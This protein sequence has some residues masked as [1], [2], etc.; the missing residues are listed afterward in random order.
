MQTPGDRASARRPL[1]LAGMLLIGL[2]LAIWFL[3]RD[4]TQYLTLKAANFTPY[5]W[6]RRFGLL[7]H[8]TG[9]FLA[10]TVGLI[11]V[12]L[13]LTGRTTRLHRNLGRLYLLG[14]VV[15][16]A[17]AFYL[18]V[19]FP[20]PPAPLY[21]SG[22]WVLG[23]AWVTTT[24]RAYLAVRRGDIAAHRAWMI[25]SY[26]VTFGFVTLRVIQSALM[27]FGIAN[28]DDSVSVAAW[29]C[30]TVPLALT[31]IFLRSHSRTGLSRA[32]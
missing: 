9:G 1:P 20:P 11:Q 7:L 19:T 24:S 21:A 23:I 2:A 14:V 31:E 15:G 28:E 5:Y 12:W 25:R 26:V 13:G 3:N 22:L 8:I 32:V 10:L 18:A 17:G 27:A 30:W 4:A 16:S 6:P 29:L